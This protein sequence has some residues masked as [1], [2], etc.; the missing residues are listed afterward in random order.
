LEPD[1]CNVPVVFAE[2]FKDEI[3][4]NDE[5]RLYSGVKKIVKKYSDNND[6]LSIINEYT[7]VISGGATLDEI[8]QITMDE[9]RHP[10]AATD[11]TVSK[12]CELH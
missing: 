10:S 5:K 9:A 1:I 12:D 8:L 2:M 11:I 3:N 7:R 6:A 4:A